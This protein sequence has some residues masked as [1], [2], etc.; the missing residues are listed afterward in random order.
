MN[1]NLL[2]YIYI[3]N[4]NNV[5]TISYTIDSILSQT[6]QNIIIKILFVS[7]LFAIAYF[8]DTQHSIMISVS[9][10]MVF[11]IYFLLSLYILQPKQQLG[12]N[13]E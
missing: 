3:R 11:G 10:V 1:N 4:F 7:L 2:V 8:L 12:G 13:F 9:I 6:Y 5:Q